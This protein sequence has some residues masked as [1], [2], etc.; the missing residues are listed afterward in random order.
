MMSGFLVHKGATVL[1]LHGGTAQPVVVNPR[2][3]VSGQQIVTLTTTYAITKCSL[4]T[5][6]GP[7]CASAIW[8]A[9]ATRVNAGGVPVVLQNSK[10]TCVSTGTGLNVTLTQTRVRGT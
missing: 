8:T 2:V 9:A 7:F 3:K 5:S 4:T 1:C 10:A 6:S